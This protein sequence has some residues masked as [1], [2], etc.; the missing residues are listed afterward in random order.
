[1]KRVRVDVPARR[2][3][4]KLVDVARAARVSTATVSRA[5]SFPHKVHPDTLG[6]IQRTIRQVGYVPHGP[7]R[8]LALRRSHT[9]GAVV[10]SLANAIFANTTH[11]LQKSLD[12]EGYTLLLGCHEYDLQVEARIARKLIERGVDGLILFGSQHER[13][14]WRLLDATR[15]PYVL[16]WALDPDGERPCV[17]FDSRDAGWRVAQYLL[18]LGH[19]RIGVVSLPLDSNERHRERVA[20]VRD[21][22]A[23]RG[24]SLP[25]ERVIERRLTPIAGRE[26]MREL[27]RA[28]TRPTAV[29]CCNDNLAIG[30]IAECHAQRLRVPADVSVCGFDDVEF[31]AMMT[32]ALTTV[33]FPAAELGR[34][35]AEH[36]LGR[37]AGREPPRQQQLPVELIVRGST[38]APPRAAARSAA[39]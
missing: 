13:E 30:A 22:L 21:A 32:P 2:E 17:G 27:L 38:A 26:A 7:A 11:A 24:L 1:M 16:T 9:I 18:D 35:A 33:F 28:R 19:R 12:Q 31:A 10:P 4:P 29:I 8:A 5:L 34:F 20:G 23:A 36:L 39:E 25:A 3:A 37:L 14:L 15:L 6:R